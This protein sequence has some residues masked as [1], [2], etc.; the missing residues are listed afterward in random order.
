MLV[1]Q[2]IVGQHSKQK[3]G[4]KD[5]SNWS[6]CEVLMW[7][8]NKFK[9]TLNKLVPLMVRQAYHER[10]QPLSVR[11]ELVEGLV[12]TFLNNEIRFCYPISLER[13]N[14]ILYA[15]TNHKQKAQADSSVVATDISNLFLLF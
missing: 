15:K 14:N 1:K 13:C 7:M 2:Y 8:R 9:E 12:Q 10:N 5:S 6:F 3:I 11:P 4:G